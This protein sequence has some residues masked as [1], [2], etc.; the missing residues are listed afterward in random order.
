[1]TEVS[2]GGVG[3]VC[4]S[5]GVGETGVWLSGKL[6]EG[7][8]GE[9]GGGGG[10][11]GGVVEEIP[12]AG[13]VG[14]SAR[15]VPAKKGDVSGGMTCGRGWYGESTARTTSGDASGVAALPIKELG[16]VSQAFAGS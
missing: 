3:G 4:A 9:G 5:G 8:G 13:G 11:G 1:M 10:G 2:N 16:G 7:G 6:Y 14:P 12:G 15:S